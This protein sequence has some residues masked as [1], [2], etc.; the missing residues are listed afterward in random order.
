M[1]IDVIYERILEK[2]VILDE[3]EIIDKLELSSAGAATGSEALMLTGSFLSNLKHNNSYLYTQLKEEIW[4]Y[5]DYCKK[6]G[7]IIK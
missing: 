7:L 1:D 2:L 4:E 5:L 3:L 6:N